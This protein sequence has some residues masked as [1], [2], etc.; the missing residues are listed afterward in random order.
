MK[1]MFRLILTLI[2]V[3]LGISLICLF[4]GIQDNLDY[5]LI[6]TELGDQPHWITGTY[7][8]FLLVLDLVFSIPTLALALFSG[9]LLGLFWGS[10]YTTI[11]LFISGQLGY[12]IGLFFGEKILIL[13]I[14]NKSKQKE[15][16]TCYKEYGGAMIVLSRSIPM[17]PEVCSFLAGINKMPWSKFTLFWCLSIIPYSLLTNYIGVIGSEQNQIVLSIVIFCVYLIFWACARVYLKN[18]IRKKDENN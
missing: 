14:K 4:L 15:L 10:I 16:S 3:F 1:S 2:L 6:I 8:V 17:G 9:H 13:V 12:L 11:G 7:I 5:H 18:I